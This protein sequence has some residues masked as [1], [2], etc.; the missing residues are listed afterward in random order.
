MVGQNNKENV[1]PCYFA[2]PNFFWVGQKNKGKWLRWGKRTR[3]FKFFF[4]FFF[5]NSQVSDSLSHTETTMQ[6]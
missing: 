1:P 2:P 4:G 3:K 6:V 5:K